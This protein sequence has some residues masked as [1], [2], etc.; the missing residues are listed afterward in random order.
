M[1]SR[2]ES[3]A[4]YFLLEWVGSVLRFPFWWYGTGFFG[5]LGWAQRGIAYRFRASAF[6]LWLK[7]F[8]VPMYG[9]HDW[10][11][12]LVSVV[13]RFVVLIWRCV[14]MIAETI[15]YALAVFLWLLVPLFVAFFL[16][17]NLLQG[18]FV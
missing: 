14:V 11:G 9:Q 13:M 12:R 15:A 18:A 1:A 10:A 3:V 16:I 7:H 6:S 17:V 2:T 4:S 5:V 8:F